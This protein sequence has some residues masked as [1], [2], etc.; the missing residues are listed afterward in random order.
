ML[1]GDATDLPGST[2][3]VRFA[4]CPLG[5][6]PL[7]AVK[8]LSDRVAAFSIVIAPLAPETPLGSKGDC[9]EGAEEALYSVASLFLVPSVGLGVVPDDSRVD[10]SVRVRLGESSSGVIQLPPFAM[11]VLS[12]LNHQP[13]FPDYPFAAFAVS[14]HLCLKGR[15][16]VVCQGHVDHG[17]VGLPT[18]EGL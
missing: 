8:A 4:T 9:V 17:S 2:E 16:P 13:S 1:A 12:G 14:I 11:E 15:V 6:S 10:A 5:V 3:G 18:S 7:A